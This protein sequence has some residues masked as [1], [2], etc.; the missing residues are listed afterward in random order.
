MVLCTS[1]LGFGVFMIGPFFIIFV[2]VRCR[3]RFKKR[4][5]KLI[6]NDLG[7][8]NLDSF[9][10]QLINKTRII[11]SGFDLEFTARKEG[12]LELKMVSPYTYFWSDKLKTEYF[13][14]EIDLIL[15][16]CKLVILPAGYSIILSPYTFHC[17][18][19]LSFSA[20]PLQADPAEKTKFYITTSFIRE[21]RK[22]LRNLKRSTR[23]TQ[24]C[25]LVLEEQ[26]I[27]TT[28]IFRQMKRTW[29]TSHRLCQ[30]TFATIV[31]LSYINPTTYEASFPRI[32]KDAKTDR[33]IEDRVAKAQRTLT[34]NT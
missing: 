3:N 28:T 16:A 20:L 25:L 29:M 9:K 1:R 21:R 14:S 5:L 30:N 8:A 34:R 2:L 33:E 19:I 24:Q 7:F 17:T 4:N 22:E 10:E 26:L 31:T 23:Q 12:I 18:I 11:R 32:S 15:I 13:H 27:I 6:C